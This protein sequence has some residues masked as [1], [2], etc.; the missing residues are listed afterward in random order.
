MRTALVALLLLFSYSHLVAQTL[1]TTNG[2]VSRDQSFVLNGFGGGTVFWWDFG[3]G[4]RI[5]GDTVAYV[6]TLSDAGSYTVNAY[7]D[8]ATTSPLATYNVEVYEIPEVTIFSSA[9]EGC[10]PFDV[11]FW[12][13][14]NFSTSKTD[15]PLGDLTWIFG[16]GNSLVSADDTVTYTYASSL[17]PGNKYQVAVEIATGIDLCAPYA[18]EEDFIEVWDIPEMDFE[19]NSSTPCEASSEISFNNNTTDVYALT[20]QWD[21]GDGTT[22]TNENPPAKT[23]PTG[24]Y[25]IQLIAT[26]AQGCR[27]SLTITES[28]GAP[29]IILPDTVCKDVPLTISSSLGSSYRSIDWDFDD[30][31]EYFDSDRNRY[32]SI[33]DTSDLAGIEIYYRTAG[34]KY[35]SLDVAV[36]GCTTPTIIDSVYVQEILIDAIADPGA[37]CDNPITVDYQ[38]VNTDASLPTYQ[39]VFEGDYLTSSSDETATNATASYFDPNDTLE[40]GLVSETLYSSQLVVTD[41]LTGCLDTATVEF[42]HTPLSARVWFNSGSA[43]LCE[44]DAEITVTDSVT[45]S[46]TDPLVSWSWDFGEGAGFTTYTTEQDEWEHTYA[47]AGTYDVFVAV[48]NSS[49]CQDTS[50]AAE[51]HVGK[52]FSA[53]DI[54]FSIEGL[55]GT[56]ITT[57][58]KEDSFNLVTNTAMVDFSLIDAFHF[59]AD[60]NRVFHQ[61]S[62]SS[63]KWGFT[64]VGTHEVSLVLESAGC[65]SESNAQ[66]IQVNGNKAEFAFG[67]HCDTPL[68][69]RFYSSS[70]STGTQTL[71]WEFGDGSTATIAAPTHTYV[72]D[73][74]SGQDHS[75]KLTVS[76]DSGCEADEVTH[77]VQV[78]QITASLSGGSLACAGSEIEFDASGSVDVACR[79]YSFQFPTIEDVQR[80]YTHS[81]DSLVYQIPDTLSQPQEVWLVVKDDNGCQDTATFAYDPD[82]IIPMLSVS[83]TFLCNG[84]TFNLSA[85]ATS[86]NTLDSVTWLISSL[87]T[88]T[89]FGGTDLSLE[90]T[91]SESVG[92]SIFVSM[93][94]ADS[95]GCSYAIEDTLLTLFYEPLDLRTNIDQGGNGRCTDQEFTLTARD[96]SSNSGLSYSW[97]I[98]DDGL[99]DVLDTIQSGPISFATEG[100][101]DITLYGETADGCRDSVDRTITVQTSPKVG[102]SFDTDSSSD[103]VYCDPLF[104][105]LMDTTLSNSS[106]SVRWDLGNGVSSSSSDVSSFYSKGAWEVTLNAETDNGCIDSVSVAFN[107]NAPEGDFDILDDQIC[108]GDLVPF[109][110][111]DTVDVDSM[112]WVFGDGALV[113]SGDGLNIGQVMDTSHVYNSTPDNFQAVARLFLYS[114]NGCASEVSDT[115]FF[116]EVKADF[117]TLNG[118]GIEDSILCVGEGITLQS[119]AQNADTYSWII[120]NETPQDDVGATFSYTNPDTYSFTQIVENFEF[121]CVDSLTRNVV[122]EGIPDIDLTLSIDTLCYGESLTATID[123]PNDSS[124]YLWGPTEYFGSGGGSS[125]TAIPDS[126]FTLTITEENYAGCVQT[127]DTAIQVILPYMFADWDTTIQ[128]GKTAKLPIVLEELYQFDV[129][130]KEDLSCLDCDRPEVSP[131]EDAFYELYVQDIKGCFDSTYNLTVYV[132]P[133]SF[134]SMPQSFT[135]NGD[136]VNDIVFVQGWLLE[137]LLEFRVFNRWGEM[138]FSTN[139]ME[140]GWDGKYNGRLQKSDTYVYKVRAIGVDGEEVNLEGYLNLVK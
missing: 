57:T 39:W 76:D 28:I 9:S 51:V 92:D 49:G 43:L 114:D 42:T 90:Y 95:V 6:Y 131:L 32:F 47:S 55:G 134:I 31:A 87:T 79:G 5:S 73:G 105:N 37:G 63:V 121:G 25:N 100:D 74:M 17:G 33:R 83:D 99:A 91:L 56:P 35:I 1:A 60:S 111:M 52:S 88:D 98:D 66:N 64:E 59:Y 128:E 11:R 3:D 124:L 108:A 77:K 94:I 80:P 53:S 89:I 36:R 84:Q 65:L 97:D 67:S 81:H 40:Y 78:R 24:T 125:A 115:V 123:D 82:I 58:C 26:N 140:E 117:L 7:D 4:T 29:S 101:Y 22:S 103:T 107:V 8:A 106:Y 136:G 96:R 62:E 44:T 45:V 72:H 122:V 27:D 10:A 14:L 50:F 138:I 137:S 54:S 110:A 13:E 21:F 85:T 75:V 61:S 18:S 113:T 68:D 132:I 139:N 120:P 126:S 86:D 20:Y 119:Q 23:Y 71:G 116:H 69:Y 41:G 48:E 46:D 104:V 19:T 127:M 129:S 2:C 15:I 112:A 133:P 118:E 16:D 12:Y 70:I 30:G 34:M 93:R 38:L 135:P 109:T 102:F 130:P